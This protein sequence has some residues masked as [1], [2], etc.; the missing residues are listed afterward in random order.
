MNFVLTTNHPR[1]D[2]A[3][4]P[5]YVTTWREN[6]L[7]CAVMGLQWLY[8]RY[9]PGNWFR[10]GDCGWP[11]PLGLLLPLLY[12]DSV[13]PAVAGE[14]ATGEALL[15]LDPEMDW[16]ACMARGSWQLPR[17]TSHALRTGQGGRDHKRD[18]MLR[19]L[20]RVA[21]GALR[22]NI[23]RLEEE[24]NSRLLQ[25]LRQVMEQHHHVFMAAACGSLRAQRNRWQAN[26]DAL[27]QQVQV[28]LLNIRRRD[29]VAIAA[30]AE[31][32]YQH[33]QDRR[34][35]GAIR[36]L[37]FVRTAAPEGTLCIVRGNEVGKY[38]II[39]SGTMLRTDS[40]TANL[41]ALK[42]LVETLK[43][44][45]GYDI[46][47]QSHLMMPNDFA[48]LREGRVYPRSLLE[49]SRTN[50]WEDLIAPDTVQAENVPECWPGFR[51]LRQMLPAE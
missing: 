47:V 2:T 39:Q 15:R 23:A 10:E 1:D 24:G 18:V 14:Y 26:Y 34:H 48:A 3:S 19:E 16:K 35:D 30:L 50:W 33:G 21:A 29:A 7:R 44:L 45:R 38:G 25:H 43:L 32:C 41:K 12:P 22:Q 17:A 8:W 40:S 42:L 31:R 9:M 4:L 28:A 13:R 49:R 37:H 27:S 20:H 36:S 51:Q 11:Q 46:S 5:Q 6:E